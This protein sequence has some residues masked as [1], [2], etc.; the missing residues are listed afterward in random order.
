MTL[1]ELR[2]RVLELAA[3]ERR[4]QE[5]LDDVRQARTVATA[6]LQEAS[7]NDIRLRPVGERPGAPRGNVHRSI[8]DEQLRD[9]IVKLGTFTAS[10]L[11]AE[12]G[13]STARARIELKRAM[14]I[15][16]PDGSWAGRQ[17]WAYVAPEGPGA[18]FEA[19]QRLKPVEQQVARGGGEIK[20]SIL[21]MVSHK[22]IKEVVREALKDGW[23]LVHVGGKHP[24]AL[25][26]SGR[27]VGI[28]STPTNPGHAAKAI[29]RQL[30]AS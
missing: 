26:K 9:A 5:C 4:L 11:G 14:H 18:A 8:S 10:E 16:K 6:N 19:Q 23:E 17:M 15:V 27:R 29:R 24:L 7:R 30:R 22:E 13:C 1:E 2:E 12:L 21:S 20:Q 25:V 3:M 28:A